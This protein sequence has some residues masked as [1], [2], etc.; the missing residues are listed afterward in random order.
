MEGNDERSEESPTASQQD[1]TED[2]IDA[3]LQGIQGQGGIQET[4]GGNAREPDFLPQ[5]SLEDYIDP[6]LASDRDPITCSWNSDAP[7]SQPDNGPGSTMQLGG[8]QMELDGTDMLAGLFDMTQDPF[9]SHTEW[10]C[11]SNQQA[12]PD[13]SVHMTHAGWHPHEYFQYDDAVLELPRLTSTERSVK[14]A[15]SLPVILE[16][17]QEKAVAEFT[18]KI[19]ENL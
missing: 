4:A 8:G 14:P 9:L 11:I 2:N 16:R 18:P 10:N 17:Y 6:S 1:S 5:T 15:D 3:D 12:S 7:L 13:L 19:S